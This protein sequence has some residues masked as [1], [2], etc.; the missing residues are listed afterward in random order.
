[1]GAYYQIKQDIELIK[2]DNGVLHQRDSK[3]ES[4]LREAIN[5]VKTQFQRMD[6]KLDRLIE[7]SK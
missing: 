6:A 4:D 2:A 7:R 3:T 1:V 5:E